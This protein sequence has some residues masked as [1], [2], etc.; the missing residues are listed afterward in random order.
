MLDYIRYNV[1]SSFDKAFEDAIARHNNEKDTQA[2]GSKWH[3]II[4]AN[5]YVLEDGEMNGE[6]GKFVGQK[7][8][9]L[10]QLEQSY[11]GLPS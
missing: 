11:G 5:N 7:G 6:Y 8:I 10:D 4:L 3:N 1:R 9:Y 2:N